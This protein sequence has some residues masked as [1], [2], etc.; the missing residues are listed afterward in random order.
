MSG[1]SDSALMLTL[2]ALQMLVLLLL[3]LCLQVLVNWTRQCSW[4]NNN[5]TATSADCRWINA[6][7]TGVADRLRGYVISRWTAAWITHH[8]INDSVAQ[9]TN[10]LRLH[11]TVAG[12]RQA[13][14]ISSRWTNSLTTTTTICRLLD[15]IISRQ[16]SK[17]RTTILVCNYL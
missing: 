15:F 3:L 9:V 2:C 6:S 7:V 10:Y 12:H 13:V 1:A 16:P 8:W 17:S 14:W 11:R 4:R 5:S